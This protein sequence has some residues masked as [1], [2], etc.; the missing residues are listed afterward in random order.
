MSALTKEWDALVAQVSQHEGDVA[1]KRSVAE[2]RGRQVA[3][4]EKQLVDARAALEWATES[5]RKLDEEKAT[6]EE[7]LKKADLPGED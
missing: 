6:L 2:E 3:V 4:E 5:S 7:S 1:D